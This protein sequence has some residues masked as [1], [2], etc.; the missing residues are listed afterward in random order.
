MASDNQPSTTPPASSEQPTAA[1]PPRRRWRQFS[2]RTL[3]VAML[4]LCILFGLFAIRLQ[5][6]RRQAAAVATIRAVGGEVFY[7]YEQRYEGRAPAVP[8]KV[9][10]WLFAWLGPDFF[11][12]V[13]EVAM[14]SGASPSTPADASRCW[15]A[16][17]QLR[18]VE[19]IRAN[20]AWI[21]DETFEAVARQRRLRRL[22]LRKGNITGKQLKPLGVLKNLEVLA[23][24][25]NPIGDDGARHLSE[26]PKLTTLGLNE[27]EIGDEGVA[28]IVRNR[29][30]RSL[31]LS[32]T[33][34]TD[35]AMVDVAKLPALKLITLGE[36][37]ISDKGIEHLAVVPDLR[38]LELGDTLITG[39]GFGKFSPDSKLT[40]IM[41]NRCPVNDDGVKAMARLPRLEALSIR[42]STTSVTM[43]S[44]GNVE[45][46]ETL[47][48]IT[49][50][51]SG[52]TNE[53]LMRFASCPELFVVGM[54]GTQVTPDGVK[55]FQQAKPMVVILGP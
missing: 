31:Y 5:R 6:A 15:T 44:L 17:S 55:Q 9:P 10:K 16:V 11:H 35:A 14:D 19:G 1:R 40:H 18:N 50:D 54:R 21:N 43:T 20:G 13:I 39:T 27:T 51:G 37:Q 46:P 23:L 45:W 42:D 3:L 29:V 53:G 12:D 47:R 36:T 26:F 25:Y 41:L 49:L 34:V 38:S 7:D 8:S 22:F 52:L 48:E 28:C 24:D 2:L 4:L 33:R 32:K 30:I